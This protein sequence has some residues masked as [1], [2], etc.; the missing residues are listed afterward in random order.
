MTIKHY[1][2]PL[3]LLFCISSEVWSQ[4]N[5]RLEEE[6]KVVSEK[7]SKAWEFGLG[8]SLINWNRM[9]IS[10]FESTPDAY[11]YTMKVN[12][13]IGGVNLYVARELTP[14]F[15]VD[16]QGTV[17][18]FKDNP[19]QSNRYKTMTLVGPG[20]QLRL[21]P[22]FKS[23]YVEPYLRV[24]AN[25]LHKNFNTVST[26]TFVN[27]PTGEAAWKATDTWN[28]EGYNTDKKTSFPVALG[29]GVNAW[30]SNS[31]G[32][33]IQGDYIMATQKNM[34]NF[35]QIIL[36]VIWRIGG[37][38]KK[39]APIREIVTIEKPVE[40][41]VE[42][43]VERVVE[44]E[45]PASREYR[46]CDMLNNVN[47][48][49]DKS[50]LTAESEIL[51]DEAANILLQ[52]TSDRFLITG[53]T[54]ACGSDT[55]NLGLSSRRAKAVVDA[56]LKRGVPAEMLKS[57]G[58]GKRIAAMPAS[59]KNSVRVGDRKVTIERI[60]KLAYWDKLPLSE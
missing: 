6:S 29:A 47:F 54:D 35:T 23:Q 59:E 20:L 53:Y 56:L 1:I 34:A 26:G 42:R 50:T 28:T 19:D 31:L 51:L 4:V 52:M 11:H 17:G 5:T 46:L 7:S 16:L 13:L 58:V 49:F 9:Q 44:K 30:L 12:H 48:E 43:V 24:G 14:W 21:S 33:G 22:L 38:S 60:L 41:I 3:L 55:Y 10:G 25:L 27:D 18:L 2:L 40:R 39:S 57:R 15:Y 32:L 36:R 37:K 8:G 45:V